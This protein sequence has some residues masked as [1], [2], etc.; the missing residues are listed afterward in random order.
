MWKTKKLNK[1]FIFVVEYVFICVL[2]N[3]KNNKNEKF[4]LEEI[5]NKLFFNFHN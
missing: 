2:H 3:I 5:R 4:I 1:I